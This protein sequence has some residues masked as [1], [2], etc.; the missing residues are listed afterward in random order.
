MSGGSICS[1]SMRGRASCKQLICIQLILIMQNRSNRP[2]RPRYK[3]FVTRELQ[4]VLPYL[5]WCEVGLLTYVRSTLSA[6]PLLIRDVM[7]P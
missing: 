2:A 6:P 5:L 4:I 1:A 3:P 7:L